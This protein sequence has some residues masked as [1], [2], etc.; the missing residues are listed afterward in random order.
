MLGAQ[1]VDNIVY[2]VSENLRFGASL[3]PGTNRPD[4]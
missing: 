1:Q 3:T 4:L 2:N